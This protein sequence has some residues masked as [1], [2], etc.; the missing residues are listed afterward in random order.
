MEQAD[1]LVVGA[2]LRGLLVCRLPLGRGQAG[3]QPGPELGPAHLK[4]WGRHGEALAGGL[5]GDAQALADLGPGAA[6]AAGLGHEVADELV[7]A[8]GQLLGQG[9]G[10]LHPRQG[11]GGGLEPDRLDQLRH[12]HRP[13]PD[14]LRLPKGSVK[15]K[16]SRVGGRG[17]GA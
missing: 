8:G 3:P 5:L 14:K 17:H 16:L 11:A 2:D 13:H 4:R 9:E 7:G 12:P 6:V 15:T 1:E 10:G